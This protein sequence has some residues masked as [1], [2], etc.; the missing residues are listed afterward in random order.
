MAQILE[1]RCRQCGTTSSQLD[2]PIMAGYLPRCVQCGQDTLVRWQ[3][4]PAEDPVGL[5]SAG[6]ETPDSRNARIQELAVPAPAEVLSPWTQASAAVTADPSTWKPLTSG[7]Q[8]SPDAASRACT[9]PHRIYHL[10]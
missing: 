9:Q 7:A 6:A 2:G 10:L 5:D 1:V 3:D 4:V 8:T